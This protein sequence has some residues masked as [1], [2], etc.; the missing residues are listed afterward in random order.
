MRRIII[1][2]IEK[3]RNGRVREDVKWICE[4]LGFVSGRDVD[5]NSFRIMFKLLEELKKEDIVPTESI[6]RGLKM[7]S[8][9]V[10]HH[11]RNLMDTGVIVREKRKVTLRGGSLTAAI[12]EMKR[13]SDKMFER[14]LEI[15]KKID[16]DLGL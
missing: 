1:R 9:A 10:N 6:A 16:E 7:E 3:P 12:E 8:P 15:A 14:I 2:E 4:S 5:D 13:D 11:L